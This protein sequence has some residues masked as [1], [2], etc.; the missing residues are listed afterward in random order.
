VPE[1]L[2]GAHR[3]SAAAIA[4]LGGSIEKQLDALSQLSPDELRAH[5]RERFYAI[6]RTLMADN[7]VSLAR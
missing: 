2:G 6:G 1:P 7:V 5:R 4:A 3:N